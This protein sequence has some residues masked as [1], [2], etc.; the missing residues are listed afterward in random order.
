MKNR[1]LISTIEVSTALIVL[2]LLDKYLF[3]GDFMTLHPSPYLFLCVLTGA[4]YGSLF[5]SLTS[6]AVYLLNRLFIMPES[7]LF[8]MNELWPFVGIFVL[9]FL[10]GIVRDILN[11]R[12]N[13]RDNEIKLHIAK[14]KSLEENVESLKDIGDEMIRRLYFENESI[15]YLIKRLNDVTEL[16]SEVILSNALSLLYDFTQAETMSIYIKSENSSY[17]RKILYKGHS[18]MPNTLKIE[19]SVMISK[20]AETGFSILND[21]ILE[22]IQSLEPLIVCAIDKEENE[23][24]FAFVIIESTSYEKMNEQ[25]YQ[26]L[27]LA[28][29]WLEVALRNAWAYESK[30][31]NEYKYADGTWKLSHYDRISQTEKNRYDRYDIPYQE[32]KCVSDS[33]I[34]ESLVKELRAFDFVFKQKEKDSYTYHIFMTNTKGEV[35]DPILERLKNR[36]PEISIKGV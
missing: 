11:E 20:A 2:V 24:H 28:C 4:F 14:T 30:I 33:D 16:D 18:L 25:V 1:K 21:E 34:G 32:I 31:E 26:Y 13:S 19:E 10:T 22:Q 17:L 3:N 35:L 29:K 12:I 7:T 8:E 15:G 36:V 23:K 9:S 5:G 6:L 27:K